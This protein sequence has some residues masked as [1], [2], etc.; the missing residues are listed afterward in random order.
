MT[1]NWFHV[2]DNSNTRKNGVHI[3]DFRKAFHVVDH[4]ILLIKLTEMNVSNAFWSWVKAFL[5]D[6][7]YR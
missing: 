6:G 2:E 4:R 1:H 3:M 5:L 7:L